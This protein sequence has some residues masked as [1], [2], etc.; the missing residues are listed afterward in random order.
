MSDATAPSTGLTI[1]VSAGRTAAN[2]PAIRNDQSVGV[3]R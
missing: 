2:A 1:G 3:P